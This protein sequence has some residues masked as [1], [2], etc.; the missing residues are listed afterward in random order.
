MSQRHLQALGI[1]PWTRRGQPEASEDCANN[2]G[3]GSVS[4][5]ADPAGVLRLNQPQSAIGT[6]ILEW[7]AGQMSLGPDHPGGSLLVSI[8][9]A[10]DQDCANFL[11]L[12]MDSAIARFDPTTLPLVG[13]VVLC[14]VENWQPATDQHS[15]RHWVSLPSLEQMLADRQFKKLAWQ[16]LKPLAGQLG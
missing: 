15:D 1:T 5:A 3:T 12:Q 4:S 6:I 7:S 11:V 16:Q 9:A 2:V 8:L 14:L 13:S 10:I